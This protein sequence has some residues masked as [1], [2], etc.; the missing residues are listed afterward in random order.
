MV[1]PIPEGRRKPAIKAKGLTDGSPSKKRPAD[2]GKHTEAFRPNCSKQRKSSNTT[3]TPALSALKTTPAPNQTK[4]TTHQIAS[5]KTTPSTAMI[6]TEDHTKTKPDKTNHSPVSQYK[7]RTINLYASSICTQDHAST[8]PQLKQTHP[9]ASTKVT[10]STS[11]QAPSAPRPALSTTPQTPNQ[12]PNQQERTRPHLAASLHIDRETQ[13]RPQ[14]NQNPN[15]LRAA[16]A[17]IE[18]YVSLTEK[19]S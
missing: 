5:T 16:A 12:I 13:T 11:T 2:Y 9:T 19:Q 3:S 18:T 7:N 10:A 4:P 1:S 6:Y 8:K 17:L 15:L 14:P